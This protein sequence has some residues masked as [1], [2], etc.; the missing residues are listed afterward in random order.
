MSNMKVKV[1]ASGSK[2]NST[3][4]EYKN[5]R[6][7]I[8]IGMRCKYIEEKLNEIGVDPR[9]IDA[10]LITHIHSDHTM[11]LKTF[12]HKYKTLTY[13]G[14]DMNELE[15]ENKVYITSEMNIKDINV[16]AIKTSH[17][18]ESF[19]YII[20][21]DLVYITDTGY[22]NNKY[23]DIL[24]N[25]KMYIM[26]S[27]HDTEMLESG[28]YPYYLKQRIWS[29]KGHLSNKS[30]SEYLSNFVGNNT[31]CVI[32]AHLSE[33]NNTEDLARSEFT[34]RV[35]CPKLI[36]ARQTEPTEMVEV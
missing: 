27:N 16:K 3:F 20:N 21:D 7:L 26:E 8:D 6:I 11:G 24:K 1:L 22:I 29:M 17:D 18:V 36:I 33:T 25:K 9:S 14:N 5:T 10:I 30:S 31:N 4:I 13:I 32:L 23:F 2:G 28:P 15:V 19:G 12:T 35:R 34:T